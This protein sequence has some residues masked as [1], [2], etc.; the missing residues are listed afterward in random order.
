MVCISDILRKWQLFQ[1]GM[2]IAVTT[3]GDQGVCYKYHKYDWFA[4]CIPSGRSAKFQLEVGKHQDVIFPLQ[5]HH[6]LV[7]HPWVA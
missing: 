3:M 1:C 4:A 7:L 5:V 6:N 2:K